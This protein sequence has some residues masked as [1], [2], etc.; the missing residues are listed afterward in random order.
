MFV[1]F[2]GGNLVGACRKYSGEDIL[3]PDFSCTMSRSSP[4]QRDANEAH[5]NILSDH[6]NIHFST[7]APF[8]SLTEFSDS[9]FAY[10]HA[11]SSSHPPESDIDSGAP[12]FRFPPPS[13]APHDGVS[14]LSVSYGDRLD[15]PPAS[16][17]YPDDETASS[18]RSMSTPDA[19][20]DS[21]FGDDLDD[22][23]QRTSLQGP[24]IRFHSRAPWETDED[25]EDSDHNSR[26]GIIG[27]KLKA[28]MSKADSL[29][30]T[31]GKGTSL[32]S[33]P[34]VESARSQASTKSSFEVT[35]GNYSSARGALYNLARESMSTSSLP[36]ATAPS[37]PLRRT[38]FPCAENIPPSTSHCS[39]QTHGS[40]SAAVSNLGG[41]VHTPPT[42]DAVRMLPSPSSDVSRNRHHSPA[43]S[44][45]RPSQGR[46]SHD[47]FVHPYANPDLAVSYT[48]TPVTVSSQR[49]VLGNIQRRDSNTTVTDSTSTRSASFS[50]VSTETSATSLTS[51][52]LPSGNPRVN[53]K[54]ISSPI[55]LL[56]S[57]D[58]NAVHVDGSTKF[59]SLDPPPGGLDEAQARKG[60]RSATVHT[61]IPPPLERR[62]GASEVP[63][64]DT[65]DVA[66]IVEGQ[67]RGE[68]TARARSSSAGTRVR[69]TLHT[70]TVGGPQP[71]KPE[72]RDS[73][74]AVSPPASVPSGRTLKHKKSGFMRLFTGRGVDGEK[75]RTP[76]PPVPRLS[77]LYA[78]RNLQTQGNAKQKST[79][80]GVPSFCPPL[81]G[82]AASNT[83]LASAYG[84]S[85]DSG[86]SNG[87]AASPR[88]RQPPSL[89]LVAGASDPSSHPSTTEVGF[90]GALTSP[91][92][93]LSVPQSAPPGTTDFQCL[94]LRPIS[95]S[96][97]SHFSDIVTSH[98]EGSQPDV[99]TPS[100]TASSGTEISPITP[101][102]TRRS[103]DAPAGTAE[104]SEEQTLIIKALQDQLISAKK[105]WQRQIWELQ[106]QVRD[107][108]A[109]VED[110]RAADDKEYCGVCRRGEDL[111]HRTSPV[112]ETQSKKVGI[113]NR[114]RTRTGDASGK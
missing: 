66:S 27:T 30:R 72:R 44:S 21:D 77:D 58:I 111:R 78:E 18:G 15:D 103:D 67:H 37:S 113:A 107:L 38:F 81:L 56:R 22:A 39:S 50:I 49:T 76:P 13:M 79:L 28:K 92:L 48:S 11:Y 12:S 100:S 7:H 31:F 33:R 57:N 80:S 96:F 14:P 41:I 104:S 97:S 10:N 24:K 85:S 68:I 87:M 99:C 84:T 114:P 2:Q 45:L 62:D 102:S 26:S 36:A 112:D 98:E 89:Y 35:A 71:P 5:Q 55:S 1:I 73:E 40:S 52:E 64:P 53:G 110:L 9:L 94:K 23:S 43:P 69:N 4:P 3:R 16:S 54:Q 6:R 34:S 75:E 42:Y 46:P 83:T 20:D 32:T 17:L 25:G 108:K 109:E 51:R 86:A 74:P 88:K 19:E 70:Y 91:V 90:R 105:A 8:P 47:G 29:M 60:S 61:V 93:S 82:A 65:D 101:V 106:G 59:L 63:F 95:T